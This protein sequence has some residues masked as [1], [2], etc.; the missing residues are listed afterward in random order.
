[1][2]FQ[3]LT[4]DVRRHHR[5]VSADEIGEPRARALVRDMDDVVEAGELLEQLAGEVGHG[6]GS[7]RP[8]GKLAGIGLGIGNELAQGFRGHRRVHHDGGGGHRKNDD[9][10]EVLGHVVWHLAMVMGLRTM[11]LV[12]P[13]RIVWPSGCARATSPVPI[14]PVP[15]AWF[16]T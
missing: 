1:M 5:N 4:G 15:P 2:Q 14:V 7:G 3:H 13:S 10:H 16:S 12:L 8:V 11:V 9:R 6:A